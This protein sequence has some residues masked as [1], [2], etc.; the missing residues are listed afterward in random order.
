M[1]YL[2]KVKMII[3]IGSES[4]MATFKVMKQETVKLDICDRTNF[5]RW[6][7]KLMFLLTKLNISYV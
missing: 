6:R 2:N 4:N 3:T 7:D 5:T 1:V